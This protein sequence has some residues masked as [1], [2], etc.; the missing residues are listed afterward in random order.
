[1]EFKIEQVGKGILILDDPLT[2]HR[3][4]EIRNILAGSLEQVDQLA[5][6]FADVKEVDLSCLQLL[7]SAHRTSRQ[8]MKNLFLKDPPEA[9]HKAA[10]DAGY[11]QRVGCTPDSHN[12]CLW[13]R[14]AK[15]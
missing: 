15:E 9:L 7:C 2:I 4:G 11:F 5:I 8:L 1:M 3:A 10:E 6:A 12:R 13:I 14:E